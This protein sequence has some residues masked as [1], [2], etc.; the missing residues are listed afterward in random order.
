MHTK[1]EKC[2]NDKVGICKKYFTNTDYCDH[3]NWNSECGILR[4]KTENYVLRS[5]VQGKVIKE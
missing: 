1:R 4:R 5:E 2:H 3:E